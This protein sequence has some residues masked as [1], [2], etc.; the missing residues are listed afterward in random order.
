MEVV[1]FLLL[2]LDTYCQTDM[3]IL[4]YK[5]MSTIQLSDVICEP[6][7]VIGAVGCVHGVYECKQGK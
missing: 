4:H 5:Q 1:N 3:D 2:S 7:M 6:Q